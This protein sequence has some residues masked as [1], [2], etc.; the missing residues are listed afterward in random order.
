VFSTE[1]APHGRLLTGTRGQI[2]IWNLGK[3]LKEYVI[4]AHNG[5]VTS[6]VLIDNERFLS[7][8]SDGTLKMWHLSSRCC[9]NIMQIKSRP[10][11]LQV[12]MIAMNLVATASQD[13]VVRYWDLQEGKE[14]KHFGQQQ[15][16]STNCLLNN[17]NRLQLMVG[18][19]D[20]MIRIYGARYLPDRS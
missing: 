7:G 4:E 17:S 5:Y 11:L 10:C 2:A 12:S 9:T 1:L 14:K 19:A 18:S 16:K 13:G 6:L 3:K 8:S 20:H 15:H